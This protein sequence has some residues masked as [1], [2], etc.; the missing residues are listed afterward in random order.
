MD[1]V[2]WSAIDLQNVST[3]FLANLVGRVSNSHP[4]YRTL[5]NELTHRYVTER[6]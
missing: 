2:V 4:A 1:N 6:R 5:V 3:A